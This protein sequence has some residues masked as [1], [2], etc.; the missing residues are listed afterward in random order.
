VPA[1]VSFL[2]ELAQEVRALN[3]PLLPDRETVERNTRLANAACKAALDYWTR[4]AEHLNAL[5]LSGGTRYVFDARTVVERRPCHDFRVLPV[6][7]TA[8]NGAQHFES[9]ILCWRVGSAERMKMIKELPADIERA[10]ARL[11]FAGV[12]AFETQSR[13]PVTGR[14]RGVQ[15]EFTADITA[16]VRLTA[17]HDEGKVRLAL[18]NVDALERTEAE[19]PAFAIRPGELDEIARMICGR[20]NK[21]LKHAHNIARH[22]P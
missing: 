20:P 14:S 3:V 5:K 21:V 8:H 19:F 18:L 2:D 12:N 22:E 7:R 17:L 16:S 6:V 4:L 1:T 9:V 13:D 11:A 10:R 15:F